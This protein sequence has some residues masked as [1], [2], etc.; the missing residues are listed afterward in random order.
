MFLD[1]IWAFDHA[2][3]TSEDRNRTR[4][5]RDNAMRR[6][7][8][9]RSLSLKD[10]VKGL[11]LRVEMAEAT[12]E[13][14]ARISQL[15]YRTNQFNFTSIRRSE[16]EIRDVL[17]RE[18][19]HCLAVRVADRFGNYGLVGA[20][21]YDSG[22]D[23]FQVGTLLLSCRV[24]G[25]GV[26][27]EVV[28]ELGRRALREGK[29]LVEVTIRATER[30]QPAREFIAS[31]ANR[32][33]AHGGSSWTFPAQELARVQYDPESTNAREEGSASIIRPKAPDSR[34]AWDFDE[35]DLGE[36]LQRIGGEW[37]DTQ[38]LAKAIEEYRL[39][40][41]PS[42]TPFEAATEAALQTA[43]LNT[44]RKVLGR[45]RIGPH[46]NFFEVGGTSLR[47]V[48][49]IAAVK[50]ELKR[51]LSIVSLFECP[52]VALLAAAMGGS[53]HELQ[54]QAKTAGAAQRGRNRR[55][56]TTRRQ[57]A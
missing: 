48:Q 30:N 12:E 55:Y 28:A 8:L 44:W 10:Y 19:A 21:M 46:D 49:I 32:A 7:L 31:I 14:F 43:L 2:G 23:R 40:S 13:Q 27:H 47:A 25:R 50:K 42:D 24:L 39:R 1:H 4:L 5:Y 41:H 22:G 17:R 34:R 54:P 57:T 9:E 51:T 3:S 36:R 29:Q 35:V 37:H 11:Q 56:K 45:P 15:T 26:E 38:R 6:R 53:S 20:V 52:T 33:C 16:S 18:G